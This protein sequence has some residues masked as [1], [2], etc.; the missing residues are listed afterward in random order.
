MTLTELAILKVSSSPPPSQKASIPSHHFTKTALAKV[1]KHLC[2]VEPDNTSALILLVLVATFDSSAYSF[3][4][5]ILPSTISEF[6]CLLATFSWSLL[7]FL[8][9][10]PQCSVLGSFYL[11]CKPPA[12][13]LHTRS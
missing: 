5:E 6:S 8:L 3:L 4:P 12:Q 2:D 9:N 7:L 10:F 1:T 13:G 11:F